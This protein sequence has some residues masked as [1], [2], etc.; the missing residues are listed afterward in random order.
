LT[1]NL[2]EPVHEPSTCGVKSNDTAPV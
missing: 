2:D 1:A